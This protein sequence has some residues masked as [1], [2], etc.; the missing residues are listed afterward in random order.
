MT[1]PAY[2]VIEVDIKNPEGMKPYQTRV[3]ETFQA[4][5]GERIVAGG[6]VDALEGAAP[7]G[8]V[9]IVQFP[10]MAAAH[11]WHDSPAYQAILGHRLAAAESRAFLV[12]GVALAVA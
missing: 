10:D 9:V 1:N 12:E 7:Q 6:R 4:F 8:K 11:A 3:E 2:F 5:G